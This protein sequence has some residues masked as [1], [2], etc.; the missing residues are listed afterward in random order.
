MSK[1]IVLLS[2]GQDSATCAFWARQ[3]FDEIVAVSI[4]YGQRHAVEVG[5]AKKIASMLGCEHVMLHIPVVAEIGGS[6]LVSANA[7][8]E[9]SGGYQD[10]E[11]VGGLPTS[12]VPGRNALFMTL[13]ASV[14]VVR[15]AKDIVTGVCQT[16][17]SG[18]PDC[19]R[20]FVDAMERAVSL[21][22]PSSAG[23]IAIHTPLMH[24]NKA[25]TV[26]MARGLPGCWEALAETVTCYHGTRCGT[27]PACVLRA[28]GFA[29][30][31]EL[32]PAA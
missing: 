13:A 11:A 25:E 26:K 1:A 8:I 30:A 7:P 32:D 21:A 20:E 28:K 6:A 19:R 15:G 16:D 31:G 10:S 27:C 23:P 29:D 4:F 17:Y 22:M 24:M 9:A 2:G 18:Y 12:F 3:R 14:A 5:A